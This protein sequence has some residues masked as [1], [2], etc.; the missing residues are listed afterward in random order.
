MKINLN[1]AAPLII[2]FMI[3]AGCSGNVPWW[4]I[5]AIVV[6]QLQVNV[7]L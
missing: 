2:A 4:T 6:S 5:I 1:I 3:W 7:E